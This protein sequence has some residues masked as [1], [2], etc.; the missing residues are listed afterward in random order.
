MNH[1]SLS[2][3]L[4]CAATLGCTG[5][6]K[7]DYTEVF[8][9][10]AWQHP[11]QVIRSLD[12]RPGDRVAD[13]GAGEGY[14]VPYLA[15]AVGPEGRVYAV[16]VDDEITRKLEGDFAQNGEGNVTVVLAGYSDPR[17]PDGEVASGVRAST[18]PT[19]DASQCSSASAK[20]P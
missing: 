20:A 11:E 1:P 3:A 4:A 13:L 9:R 6:G 7:I 8:R 14:F 16:D 5:L 15:A 18:A 2:L 10:A 17:L 12:I 19:R